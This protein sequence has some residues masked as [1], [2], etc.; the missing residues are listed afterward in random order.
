MGGRIA[1]RAALRA[2]AIAP[3]NHLSHFALA[4]AHYFRKEFEA[5]SNAA[6]RAI[7]L[8]PR[9]GAV[10]EFI[11]RW[12]SPVTGSA[13]SNWANGRELSPHHRNWCWALAVQRCLSEVQLPQRENV[14]QGPDAGQ[15][16]RR[17][18][19]RRPLP[20]ADGGQLMPVG[21]LAFRT[22]TARCAPD[23][24][25]EM[26]GTID[27]LGSFRLDGNWSRKGDRLDLLGSLDAAAAKRFAMI[28]MPPEAMACTASGTYRA[29]ATAPT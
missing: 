8:N 16:L 3:S 9:D 5:F 26:A 7:A 11:P 10:V 21:P 4:Q 6:E 2:A 27:G 22:Y 15:F 20:A 29:A 19:I 13:A 23:G 14:P 25:F 1:L 12:R 28:G 18:L 17:L 24:G